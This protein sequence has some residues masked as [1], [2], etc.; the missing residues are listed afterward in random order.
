MLW[1]LCEDFCHTLP[2]PPADWPISLSPPREHYHFLS[3][4]S[5]CIWFLSQTVNTLTSSF[6]HSES[7]SGPP[8]GE[9]VKKYL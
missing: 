9:A 2:Q 7:G 4:V 3:H 6:L 5:M 8:T 1:I